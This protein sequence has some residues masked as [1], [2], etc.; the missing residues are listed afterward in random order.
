MDLMATVNG[1]YFVQFY[2][3]HLYNW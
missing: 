1:I 2:V 3:I